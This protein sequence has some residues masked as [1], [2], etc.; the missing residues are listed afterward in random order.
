MQMCGKRH[1]IFAG[2]IEAF[3]NF[4]EKTVA[5]R[6]SKLCYERENI[7]QLRR[8]IVTGGIGCCA[9]RA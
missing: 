4:S 6:D 5:L 2:M 9:S 7:S 3:V 1:G 8:V